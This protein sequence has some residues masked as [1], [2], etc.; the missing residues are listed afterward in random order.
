MKTNVMNSKYL[1]AAILLVLSSIMASGQSVGSVF[2]TLDAT[3]SSVRQ[4]Q[5]MDRYDQSTNENAFSLNYS[6]A[7]QIFASNPVYVQY[8]L[9]LQ[10][11]YHVNK[12]QD[13]VNYN[14]TMISGGFTVLT[15]FL[16]A[17][18][19]VNIM[20]CIPVFDT[21]LT[22]MPFAGF[23][24][25][26]YFLGRQKDTEWISING[27]RETIVDKTNLFNSDQMGGNPLNRIT[28]GWQAGA[29]LAIGRYLLGVAYEGP[30][31]NLQKGDTYKVRRSQVNICLGYMF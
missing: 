19:P 2:N 25:Q 13:D 31:S 8:G 4:K 27:D 11:S 1:F 29:K 22:L 7:R 21:S 23:N 3:Y 14:G 10:Y 18:L 24:L 30:L 9:G 5:I 26:G 20:Y 6:Q 15:S 17:K 28:V 16:S 12:D